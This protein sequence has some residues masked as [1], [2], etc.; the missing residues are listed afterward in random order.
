MPDFE[1]VTARPAASVIIPTHNGADMLC[2]CLE[3]L[4]YADLA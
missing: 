4:L 1:S 3:A 2:E